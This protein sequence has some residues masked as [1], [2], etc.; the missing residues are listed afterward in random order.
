M[1]LERKAGPR[2]K[3]SLKADNASAY[4]A[5]KKK[6][7]APKSR[8]RKKVPLNAPLSIPKNIAELSENDCRF[9]VGNPGENGFHFCGAGTEKFPYCEYHR[10]IC[11]TGKTSEQQK[12]K[13]ADARR[14]KRN[15]QL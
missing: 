14:R 3:K 9:P 12:Q 10:A 5:Q 11:Y 7:A 1:G 6:K 4:Y 8:R 13:K 2:A 15:A